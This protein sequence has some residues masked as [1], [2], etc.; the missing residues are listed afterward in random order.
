M[1]SLRTFLSE[2]D[3]KL[4]KDVPEEQPIGFATSSASFKNGF[5]DDDTIQFATST[6]S[7][8]SKDGQKLV[9]NESLLETEIVNHGDSKAPLRDPAKPNTESVH[10]HKL[11]MRDDYN[12]LATEPHLTQHQAKS[13][14]LLHSNTDTKHPSYQ[15][16]VSE[17][18]LDSEHLNK[19]L[20]KAHQR[21]STDVPEAH[22]K[23]VGHL[24][25]LMEHHKLPEKTTVYS[26]LH[27]DPSEHAG[28]TVHFPAY[29]ST[30]LSPHIA[31]NFGKGHVSS[32]E[33]GQRVVTK[34]MMRVDLPKGHNHLFTENHTHLPG[35]M[36]VVLPRNTKLKFDHEPSH[37]IKRDRYGMETHNHIW[38]AHVVHD[39]DK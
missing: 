38:N 28:K 4:A 31:A 17:Y 27:F 5:G 30:S 25:S 39:E 18:T 19:S 23:M 21:G 12:D 9:A 20:F 35:E 3:D 16:A 10:L 1:K 7:Y 22:K 14:K 24:D 2:V 34:H 8:T 15:Y 29:T 6:A 37:I 33:N 32:G 11:G 36:E 13:A 26:G